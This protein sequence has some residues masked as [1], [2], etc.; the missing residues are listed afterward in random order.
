MNRLWDWLTTQYDAD[1]PPA[2]EV[3]STLARADSM[4]A[5][6]RRLAAHL[7]VDYEQEGKLY[8]ADQWLGI[9]P[10]LEK[11]TER[12]EELERREPPEEE[13]NG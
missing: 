9:I 4:R 5:R 10:L 2:A 11:L 8:S 7:G 6:G 1:L 12:I 3:A 13:S